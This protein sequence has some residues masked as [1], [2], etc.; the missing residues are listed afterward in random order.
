MT[1]GTYDAQ[2]GGLYSSEFGLTY[3]VDQPDIGVGWFIDDIAVDRLQGTHPS[4]TRGAEVTFTARFTRRAGEDPQER[5][6]QLRQR[7]RYAHTVVN[8]T[9]IDGTPKFKV[10]REGTAS[11]LVA[12]FDP[13]FDVESGEGFWGLLTGYADASKLPGRW[14]VM[15]LEVRVLADKSEYASD[16][17][18]INDLGI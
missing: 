1:G 13:G 14:A 15:E 5:Y 7:L 8:K 3:G 17:E 6:E 16:S 11:D 2:D 10:Q 18:V 4:V 12:L 9:L